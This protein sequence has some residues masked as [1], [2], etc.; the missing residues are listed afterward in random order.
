M[1]I[2]C[3]IDL[4]QIDDIAGLGFDFVDLNGQE[5][6]N[7]TAEQAE[8]L[9]LRLK[10]LRLPCLGLHATVPAKVR[11]NG[12]GFDGDTAANYFRLL[13]QRAAALDVRYLGIGSPAARSLPDG[14]P[15]EAADDEFCASLAA[16][17]EA[18]PNA[19]VLVEALNRSETNYVNSYAEAC[20][21]VRRAAHPA[22]R[23][24]LDLYHFAKCGDDPA[25]LDRDEFGLACYLH[26]ADPEG[27]AFLSNATSP[28]F[29]K[30]A[31]RI[32]R[33]TMCAEIAI[34]AVT[35]DLRRDAAAALA[36]LRT[37]FAEN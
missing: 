36:I 18:F 19:L 9:L 24:V 29:M 30:M 11:L 1:K 5:L 25:A 14:Y 2:G 28:E 16:A 21:L 10:E 31:E 17:A 12:P 32:A 4:R 15:R 26:I 23:T 35:D 8:R 20:V 7:C 13:A 37:M 22:V 34:E 6:A 33:R 27:R 3:C